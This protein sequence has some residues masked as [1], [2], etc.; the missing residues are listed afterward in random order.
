MIGEEDES[1]RIIEV[2]QD[3]KK[4]AYWKLLE[5][6]ILEWIEEENKRL[7]SYKRSGIS[8]DREIDKYNRAVDRIV[9]LKRFLVINETMISYHTSFLMRVKIEVGNMVQKAESFF[10]EVLRK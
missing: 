6:A 5:R 4:S 2:V 9:Y 8:K 3:G 7:D 1:R 10:E